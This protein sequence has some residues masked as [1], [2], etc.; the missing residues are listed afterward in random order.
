MTQTGLFDQPQFPP[1]PFKPGSQK[2]RIYEELKDGPITNARIIQQ[3]GIFNST[4]RCSEIREFLKP[5]GIKL[6]CER[7]RGGLF[8]YRIQ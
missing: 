1:N 2:Y 6:H 3:Y 4:G 7:L 8:E 5:H